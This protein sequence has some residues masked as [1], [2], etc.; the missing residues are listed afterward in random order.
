[1][2]N[3]TKAA[4]RR[5]LLSVYP[6][7]MTLLTYLPIIVVI[8]Y[9]FNESR[10]T[11]QWGGF[12]LKWYEALSRDR[13]MLEALK[14]SLFLAATSAVLAALIATPAAIGMKRSNLPLRGV[15]EKTA[16]LPLI[17]PEI[18][19]GMVLLAFFHMVGMSLGMTTLVIAHTAF[20]IPYV[21]TQV[22]AGLEVLDPSVTEAALDLGAGRF[23][24]FC[25]VTLP[26]IAPAVVSGMFMSFA[27]SFDDV[28]ISIFVT[29][30]S[31]NTLPIRVYTQ[32]KTSVTPEI[33]AL[34]TIMVAVTV[35]CYAVSAVARALL[36][37]RNKIR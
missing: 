30:P 12:S 24:A 18:I 2:K 9:S 17:I 26:L 28:I 19:L 32:L 31:V 4:G 13:D 16:L 20:C 5:A 29:G 8:V 34:C 33:N 25:T 37:K 3:N 7:I 23:T 21:Y 35:I 1:M 22:R 14:N 15:M 11:S 6:I 36:K 27:M 10:L